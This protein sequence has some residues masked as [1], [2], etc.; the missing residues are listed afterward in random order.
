MIMAGAT[1]ISVNTQALT[2]SVLDMRSQVVSPFEEAYQE[3]KSCL[4]EKQVS[5]RSFGDTWSSVAPYVSE[6]ETLM[7][8]LDSLFKATL[9]FLEGSNKDYA[10]ADKQMTLVWSDSGG[11]TGSG[12]FAAKKEK[13]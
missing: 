10:F 6:L 2:T 5:A 3:A 13:H 11:A 1:T 12:G 9:R 4:D 8:T 7:D